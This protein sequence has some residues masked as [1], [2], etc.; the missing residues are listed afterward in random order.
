MALTPVLTI[1]A[2]MYSENPLFLLQK[3]GSPTNDPHCLYDDI[4][5]AR[6][7]DEVVV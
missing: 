6:E 5:A 7:E 2:C 1:F 3:D 4:A